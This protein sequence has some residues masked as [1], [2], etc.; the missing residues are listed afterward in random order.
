MQQQY[1]C[2]TS[3][4]A[5]LGIH[6]VC[7]NLWRCRSMPDPQGTIN[8]SYVHGAHTAVYSPGLI[9]PTTLMAGF[10]HQLTHLWLSCLTFQVPR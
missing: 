7:W 5:G 3:G 6:G 4:Q 9:G 10:S 8:T 2:E 1:E